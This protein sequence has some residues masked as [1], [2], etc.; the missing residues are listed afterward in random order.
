MH[1]IVIHFK[2]AKLKFANSTERLNNI[3][4]IIISCSFTFH[5]CLNYVQWK[6]HTPRNKRNKW[7]LNHSIFPVF[8]SENDKNVWCPAIN[9]DKP[10]ATSVD[11]KLSFILKILFIYICIWV[12]IYTKRQCEKCC[13]WTL[14]NL[15]LFHIAGSN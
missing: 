12:L 13:F 2:G 14:T 7:L 15:P 11:W 9:L 6:K 10:F 1:C 3:S 4:D 8:W 5:D